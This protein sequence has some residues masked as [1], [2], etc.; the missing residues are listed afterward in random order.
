MNFKNIAALIALCLFATTAIAGEKIHH[1]IEVVVIGADNDG[2]TRLVLDSDDLGFDL[3]DMQ[4]GENQSIVDKDGRAI[5]VTRTEEGFTF[6]VDG[7][8]IK[9]PLFEGHG[10]SSAWFSDGDHMS[11]IDIRVMHDGMSA[12][13]MHMEGVIIFSGKEIDAATQQV[14]RSALEL[15]GHSEVSFAGGDENAPH[16]VR[17]IKK[18]VEVTE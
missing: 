4:V 1:N 13:S 10:G 3:H 15:A 17:V 6:D 9:M 16:H 7:K 14:I 11:D 12:S 18:V 2:E 5:L 8:T